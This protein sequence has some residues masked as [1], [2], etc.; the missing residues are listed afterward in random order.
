MK[1]LEAEKHPLTY[2][3]LKAFLQNVKNKQIQTFMLQGDLSISKNQCT[4]RKCVTLDQG[5]NYFD[6]MTLDSMSRC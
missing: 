4:F 1:S 2:L 3:D 5:F 6:M